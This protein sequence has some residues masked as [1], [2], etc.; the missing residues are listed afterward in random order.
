MTSPAA[1]AQGGVGFNG[2]GLGGMH[3]PGPAFSEG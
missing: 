3:F 1:G 2:S